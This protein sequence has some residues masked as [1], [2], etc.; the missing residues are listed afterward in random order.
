MENK[1]WYVYVL[2]SET[3]LSTKGNPIRYVGISTDVL[4][5]L[6]KHNSG[7]GAKATRGKGPWKLLAYAYAGDNRGKAQ[8]W[9]FFIRQ[10]KKNER[11][12]WIK[13]N[14]YKE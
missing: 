12:N 8:W 6:K 11:E 14:K 9:E 13:E 10:L 1:K 7:K 5:R 3:A 2:Q 4:A